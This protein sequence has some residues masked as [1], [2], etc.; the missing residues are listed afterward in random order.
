MGRQ[1]QHI[2][3]PAKKKDMIELD[4]L[5]PLYDEIP[6][7]PD[8]DLKIELFEIFKKDFIDNPFKIDNSKVKIILEKSRIPGFRQYPET[9]VHII[10]RLSPM[11]GKRNFEPERANRIH[12]IKPILL[13]KDN[14]KIKFFEFADDDGILKYHYWFKEMNFMIVLKPISPDVLII[15]AFCVD[16]MDRNKYNNRYFK[17]R[18]D[19]K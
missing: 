9:F 6:L 18:K 17:Y 1:I 8:E 11:R 16:K 2:R 3:P 19:I 7:E 5:E 12:W 10:T 13:Q 15:T 4:D 14:S